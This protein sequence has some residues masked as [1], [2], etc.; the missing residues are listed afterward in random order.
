MFIYGGIFDVYK[1]KNSSMTEYKIYLLAWNTH[2][3]LHTLL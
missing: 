3:F 2:M 1:K